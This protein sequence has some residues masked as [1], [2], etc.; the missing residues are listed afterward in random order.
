DP[1]QSGVAIDEID[2]RVR[3]EKRHLAFEVA[4]QPGVVG[5]EERD[6]TAARDPQPRVA[7]GGG[8]GM[9]F[10]AVNDLLEVWRQRRFELGG[11]RRAVVD[12]DQLEIGERLGEDGTDGLG[13]ERRSFVGGNNYADQRYR[14]IKHARPS[15]VAPCASDTPS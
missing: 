8:A 11:V 7:C 10:A 2:R 13:D 6:V 4:R 14:L 9:R 12:D 15:A 3:V 5:V 1:G